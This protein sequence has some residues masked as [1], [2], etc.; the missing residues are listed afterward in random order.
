ME[1]TFYRI[2]VYYIDLYTKS[3]FRKNS[4]TLEL[5]YGNIMSCLGS[6]N[7]EVSLYRAI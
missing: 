7:I 1:R 6:Y 4:G 2:R 3:V 5:R